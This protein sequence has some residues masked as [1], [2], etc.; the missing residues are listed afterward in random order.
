MPLSD[1][2]LLLIVSLDELTLDELLTSSEEDE[3]CSSFPISK[4]Q[5]MKANERSAEN[6]AV[7]TFLT[8]ILYL[9]GLGK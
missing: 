5:E 3:L 6:T 2:E 9:I 1:E 4:E 7:V 8:V